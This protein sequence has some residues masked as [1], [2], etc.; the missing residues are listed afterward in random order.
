MLFMSVAE[1]KRTLP[2]LGR[3]P[4]PLEG[5][6]RVGSG[7]DDDGVD[8]DQELGPCQRTEHDQRVGRW[9]LGEELHAHRRERVPILEPGRLD[10]GSGQIRH[11]RPGRPGW[12]GYT[13]ILHW[14]PLDSHRS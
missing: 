5:T 3:A 2:A 8:L 6:D 1:G 13:G 9:G 10:G 11:P 7:Q 14:G 12:A 4:P